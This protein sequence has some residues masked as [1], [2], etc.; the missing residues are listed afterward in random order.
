MTKFLEKSFS[1]PVGTTPA[2]RDNYDRIFKRKPKKAKKQA[3]KGGK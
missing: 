3:K 2:Y 1:V